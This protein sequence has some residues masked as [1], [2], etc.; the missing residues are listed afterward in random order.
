MPLS[1]KDQVPANG[2]P[3]TLGFKPQIDVLPC[4]TMSEPEY[5]KAPWEATLVAMLPE[6]GMSVFGNSVCS[7]MVDDAEERPLSHARK[8]RCIC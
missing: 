7:V 8:G 4:W 6:K 1:T 3:T 2:E 5:V